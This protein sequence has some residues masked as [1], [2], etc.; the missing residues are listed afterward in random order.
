MQELVFDV[1]ANGFLEEATRL[2]LLSIG[3][4]VAHTLDTYADQP[5]FKPISEGIERLQKADVIV[6]HKA[7][8]YDIPV[9]NKIYGEGTLNPRKVKDTLVMSRLAFPDA[10]EHSID[11]WGRKFGLPKIEWTKGFDRWDPEMVPY[12]ERDTRIAGRVYALVK[13]LMAGWGESVQLEHDVAAIIHRQEMNGFGFDVEKAQELEA[14][15]RQEQSEIERRLQE[16][17]PPWFVAVEEK[18]SK[19]DRRQK[20]V[21]EDGGVNALYVAEFTEGIKHTK[22]SLQ[23]FNPGSRQQVA[24]RL[25]RKYGWKPKHYTPSGEVQVDE[26]VLA[27]LDYPEAAELTRFMRVKKQLGMLAD[28]ENAWL[29]L[30][31]NGRIYGAVN[32]NGAVTGRMS[33]FKPNVAQADK[34]DLRMRAVWIPRKGWVLVGCDAEGLEL[35][36]MGHYLAP[37]DGGAFIKSLL[38]GDKK[39]GTDPHSVNQRLVE[40]AKR[41]DAKTFIYALI[42]GAGDEK[43]G[44]IIVSSWFEAGQPLPKS[45]KGLKLRGI[46]KA[47]RSRV[48]EGVKGFK[49]LVE[50]VRFKAKNPG[51]LIGLDGRRIPVRSQH[52]ALNT[53]FQSGGAIVMKKALVLF[54]QVMATWDHRFF[55]GPAQWA[56]CANVHDEVQTECAPEIAEAIGILFARCITD[57]GIALGVRCPLAGDYAIGTNWKETH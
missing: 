36:M 28:G 18:V 55:G 45:Y 48:L 56:Y 5:G 27:D 16:I 20:V 38:E 42:Y 9:I 41:D 2:W 40:L 52:S 44:K 10:Q 46:G 50:A 15:L 31:K 23:L 43:L 25:I 49:G 22:I 33:H 21:Y 54:D 17:F 19:R 7:L 47:A 37:F 39:L 1:E 32:T 4:P 34:K 35:R 3:D 24:E 14:E 12:V 8:T 57:A 53:L 29:K 51:Y 13:P 30:V 6:G 11:A 26:T